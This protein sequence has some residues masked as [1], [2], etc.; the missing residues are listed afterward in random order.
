[1]LAYAEKIV[2]LF[3]FTSK[4]LVTTLAYPFSLKI[5]YLENVSTMNARL[6]LVLEMYYYL[7]RRRILREF[8]KVR[9]HVIN[10]SMTCFRSSSDLSSFPRLAKAN[11]TPIIEGKVVLCEVFTG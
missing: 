1:M 5:L 7:R 2:R 6:Y 9:K 10:R 11:C 3:D 8:I 4:D